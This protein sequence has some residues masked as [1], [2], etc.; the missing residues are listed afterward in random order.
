MRPRR[1]AAQRCSVQPLE[2]ALDRFEQL[3]MRARI[4]LAPQDL[5][6]PDDGERG[7]PVAQLFA[8]TGHFL[9]N[10]GLGGGELAVALLLRLLTR[11]VDELLTPLLRLRENLSR[12]SARFLDR[13]IGLTR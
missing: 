10:F 8:R 3:A 5:L 1:T 4:D 2:L 12:A 13:L 7:N 11:M 9:V 6:R